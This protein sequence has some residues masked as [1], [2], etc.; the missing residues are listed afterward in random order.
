M[1]PCL[2]EQK[3]D[4]SKELRVSVTFRSSLDLIGWT[5][6]KSI[7]YILEKNTRMN[8]FNL[9]LIIARTAWKF[10][11]SA[12]MLHSDF[13][14]ILLVEGGCG[15][16]CTHYCCGG[17]S[18]IVLAAKPGGLN[19]WMPRMLCVWHQPHEMH[20]RIVVRHGPHRYPVC[21]SII[22]YLQKKLLNV[23]F[24]ARLTPNQKSR[25]AGTRCLTGIIF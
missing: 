2:E 21:A 10:F 24:H 14:G 18:A 17:K 22:A 1:L 12:A 15:T 7:S 6:T 16:F 8:R 3:E 23:P 4:Y 5:H 11:H 19:G 13:I 20:G 25:F 9:N